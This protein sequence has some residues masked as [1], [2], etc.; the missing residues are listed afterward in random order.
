VAAIVG[1]VVIAVSLV[2]VRR[3]RRRALQEG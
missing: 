1:I 3:L 2:A